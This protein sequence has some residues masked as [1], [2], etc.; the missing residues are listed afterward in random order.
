MEEWWTKTSVEPSS[1]TI[2]PKPFL[3]SNH[4]TVPEDIESDKYR[5]APCCLDTSPCSFQEACDA[6]SPERVSARNMIGEYFSFCLDCLDF[7]GC[8]V[9]DS[10]GKNLSNSYYHQRMTLEETFRCLFI[11]F[12]VCGSITPK[13]CWWCERSRGW[14]PHNSLH[15]GY[16]GWSKC[17][18]S[19]EIILLDGKARAQMPSTKYGV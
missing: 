9:V 12:S 19:G 18:T 6:T 11:T 7:S 3:L 8:F 14:Q 17:G 16:P 4:F 15:S 5:A 2:N 10:S 13:A 1:G